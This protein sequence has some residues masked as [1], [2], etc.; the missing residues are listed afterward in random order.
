MRTGIFYICSVECIANI[1]VIMVLNVFCSFSR[2]LDSN[3]CRNPDNERQPWCYTTDPNT[4]W[5]YCQVPSCN[6]APAPG[7]RE[8]KTGFRCNPFKKLVLFVCIACY[9][10]CV[11]L[12]M[13]LWSL[14][15]K[16]IVTKAMGAVTAASHQKLSVER[17]VKRG[18]PWFH[19]PTRKHHKCSPARE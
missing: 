5:E 12:K 3:Y 4:R 18:A 7:K 14:L 9:C 10:D 1:G 17:N 11:L 8:L 19:T 6:N 15:M 16:R 13:R 2:G